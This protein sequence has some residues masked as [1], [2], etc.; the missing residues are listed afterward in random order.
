MPTTGELGDGVTLK[1]EL[2]NTPLLLQEK[3]GVTQ[4]YVA[5][6]VDPQV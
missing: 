5:H 3:F 4:G 2:E 1:A 6:R